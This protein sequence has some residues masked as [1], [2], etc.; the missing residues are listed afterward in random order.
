[1][2]IQGILGASRKH[3]L[4]E[5]EHHQA[6]RTYDIYFGLTKLTTIPDD[7]RSLLF[8]STISMLLGAGVL[9]QHIVVNFNLSYKTIKKIHSAFAHSG[10]DEELTRQL[11]NPGRKPKLT[12]EIKRAIYE[13][14]KYH[15]S[16][17]EYRFLKQTVLD[18]KKEFGIT[19]SRETVRLELLKEANSDY[20]PRERTEKETESASPLA[21]EIEG[22]E[23]RTSLMNSKR[24]VIRNCYA[25]MLLLGSFLSL[26]FDDFPDL[27]TSDG[28]HTLKAVLIWWLV[29]ILVGAKNMER[30]RY[31]HLEDFENITGFNG[32]PPVEAM[33]TILHELSWSD[34][35]KIS[36][37]LLKKNVDYFVEDDDDYY[38]DGHFE[39][40]TGKAPILKG[41]NTIKNRVSKGNEDY[42]VHDSKGNPIFSI[43]CD[44][45]DDFRTVIRDILKTIYRLRPGRPITV[46]YD[47]GGFSTDLMQEI[48]RKPG[49]HFVTWQKGFKKQDAAGV[50]FENTI[51]IELP[52]NDLGNWKEYRV[53]FYED[54]WIC[55]GFACRRIIIRREDKIKDDK[56]FV[57]SILTS[58]RKTDG[59]KIVWKILKRFRQENDFKK[60]KHHF[61]LDEITSYGK[62]KYGT[63]GDKDPSKQTRNPAYVK[64]L[65]K[66]RSLKKEREKLFSQL[67]LGAFKASLLKNISGD[68][69]K[70]QS[71]VLNEINDLCDD[72]KEKTTQKKMIKKE[73]SKLEQ[74]RDQ[75]K[76]ELDLRAKRFLGLIKQ[77]ARN[78]FRSRSLVAS[79]GLSA[80]A[81]C[82][83]GAQ[84][85]LQ[86][87]GNLRD[88]QKVFR[89]LTRTGGEIEIDGELMHVRL[90]PFGRRRFQ[91]K[92][93]LYFE[94]INKK[95]IRTM[96][97]RYI[98]R[99]TPFP[100]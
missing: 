39:E 37:I 53:D 10:S 2:A 73:V 76:V 21:L 61:G 33:R 49:H 89:Q 88:Y 19:L 43:L 52:Y 91:E 55:K 16:C 13:R 9:V 1:M 83:Q 63:L 8:K 69:L 31:L 12:E 82:E 35:T 85:F 30:Q 26:V 65:A 75:N 66:I 7:K 95:N 78:I 41:W 24:G 72:I 80:S 50:V 81:L 22:N 100:L 51:A 74:C 15:K 58:D 27:C 70:K 79:A 64:I 34:D 47:R 62:L 3:P 40:Y 6:T 4:F 94:N 92:C 29:G 90:D 57:Q 54:E 28:R 46:I 5:V 97:G 48:T 45:F 25:G 99:F 59:G 23:E 84:D 98:V 67:G 87:Y 17:G 71:S 77:T 36:S 11:R 68:I 44:L 42:F 56:G 18:I 38:L 20:F 93:N 60:Q 86:T 96:D 32:M 14:C